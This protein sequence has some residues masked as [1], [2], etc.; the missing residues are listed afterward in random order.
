MEM[1]LEIFIP[2]NLSCKAA[3]GQTTNITEIIPYD[4]YFFKARLSAQ[5]FRLLDNSRIAIG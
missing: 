4:E 5:D 1:T 2:W 3:S